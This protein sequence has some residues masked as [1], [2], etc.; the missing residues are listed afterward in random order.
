MSTWR[1]EKDGAVS[2]Q[3]TFNP[4][5]EQSRDIAKDGVISSLSEGGVTYAYK[6]GGDKI[7]FIL[8]FKALPESDLMGGFDWGTLRQDSGTQSLINWY[9][10]EVEKKLYPFTAFDE[11]NNAHPNMRFVD[12]HFLWSSPLIWTG[13]IVLERYL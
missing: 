8:P 4:D 1:F 6:H 3:F 2:F 7:I 12:M 5:F 10:N 11:K 13:Q 9:H